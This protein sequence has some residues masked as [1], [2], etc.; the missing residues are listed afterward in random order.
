[1][2]R[3]GTKMIEG[4]AGTAGAGFAGPKYLVVNENTLCYRMGERSFEGNPWLGV[5]HGKTLLGGADWR[6]GPILAWEGDVLR[7]A[8]L[9]DFASF[10][11]L[12]PPDM[13]R[14]P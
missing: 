10:R 5:L 7:E 9:D 12:P 14:E 3:K 6:N 8:T 4:T 13:T 1:M 11:V 2:I